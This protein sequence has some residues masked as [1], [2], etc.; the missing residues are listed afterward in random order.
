MLKKLA[1]TDKLLQA[2]L[3]EAHVV[4]GGQPMLLAGDLDADP[5]VIPCLAEGNA[6][7]RFKDLGLVHSV[8][9]GTK[10]DATCRFKL[11]G[12]VGTRRD[13][14]IACP[15]ALAACLFL[16]FLSLGSWEFGSGVR[17]LLA[18][19]LPNPPGLPARWTL[20]LGPLLQDVG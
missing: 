20:Q 3:A 12:S 17:R 6:A 11:D 1:L 18:L 19:A 14:I 4:C 16:I 13:F 10:P 8:G 15:N 9:S 5:N 2:V 7:G